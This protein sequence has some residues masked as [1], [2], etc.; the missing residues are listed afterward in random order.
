MTLVLFGGRSSGI[1]VDHRF[2][3]MSVANINR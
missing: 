2:E 1:Q 3:L